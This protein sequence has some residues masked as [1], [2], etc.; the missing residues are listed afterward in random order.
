MQ[1]WA[2]PMATDI[3]FALGILVMFGERVP[4]GLKVFLVSLAIF[5]DIGAVVVIALLY[6]SGLSM[7]ALGVALGCL[8]VLY[9]INRR[10]VCTVIPYVLVGLIMWTALLKSGVHATLKDPAYPDFSPLRKLEQD[11]H[12]T[13]FFVVLP[14]FAFANSGIRLTGGE[15][16]SIVHPVPIGIALG[17][18]VGKQLGVFGFVWMSVKLGLARLPG[19]VGWGSLYGVAVLCGVGFTMS[20][21]IGSLAFE[22]SL[23]TQTDIIFD[24]R[25]GVI[26]GSLLSAVMGYLILRKTL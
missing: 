21:F 25:L 16:W 22:C 10:G 19:N 9:I 8:L 26:A 6:T 14:V 5:D 20:L 2:I 12:S 18:L 24:E 1:G 17:L 15:L 23:C 13:V 7:T 4:R 11:L 3:A